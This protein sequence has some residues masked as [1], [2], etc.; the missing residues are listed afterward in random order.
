[1]HGGS[2]IYISDCPSSLPSNP[3]ICPIIPFEFFVPPRSLS[4][5]VTMGVF[6]RCNL[7]I[8]F[9][10]EQRF[11][12]ATI[13]STLLVTCT[14]PCIPSLHELFAKLW[15]GSVESQSD[16]ERL[17][18][19]QPLMPRSLLKLFATAFSWLI[20]PQIILCFLNLSFLSFNCSSNLADPLGSRLHAATITYALIFG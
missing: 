15:L 11:F 4:L 2:R 3:W 12:S 18:P 20:S 8:I 5:L 1:M 10:S 19:P 14:A 6:E 17:P 13:T 16:E 9:I 7:C